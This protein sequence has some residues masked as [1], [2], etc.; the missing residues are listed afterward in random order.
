[1]AVLV[2]SIQKILLFSVRCTS[3]PDK[4]KEIFV[5]V[6]SYPHFFGK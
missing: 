4:D 1:M 5:L 3:Y 6:E 2:L